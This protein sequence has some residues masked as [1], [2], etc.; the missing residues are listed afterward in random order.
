MQTT[1]NEEQLNDKTQDERGMHSFFFP[2][3]LFPCIIRQPQEVKRTS[4]QQDAEVK[5]WWRAKMLKVAYTH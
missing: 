1:S 3:T 4:K 2:L 5:K